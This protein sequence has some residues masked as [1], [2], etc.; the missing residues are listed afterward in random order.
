MKKINLILL[1]FILMVS[2]FY[3]CNKNNNPTPEPANN[4]LTYTADEMALWRQLNNFNQK[5]KTGLKSEEFITPDSAMWYLEALFNV[6]QAKDTT[7]DDVKS[8]ERTYSLN[9]NTNGTVNMSDVVSV[10]NQLIADM[11]YELGQ[12]ESD[13]KFLIIADLEQES[14]KTGSF[15]MTLTAGMGINP[16]VYY[17]PITTTDDWRSG[18][19]HGHCVNPAWDSDAGLELKRRFNNP[20]MA[21]PAPPYQWINPYVTTLLSYEQ[22]PGRIFHEHAS[23]D[24][25]VE[26]TELKSLLTQGHYIIYNTPSETPS[27]VRPSNLQFRLIDLWTNN[28]N[29]T[30]NEYWHKYQIYY[31]TPVSVPPIE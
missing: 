5:I 18:N 13:Y 23:S 11:D 29:P 30:D 16:L 14:L 27:G 19:M 9:V 4:G 21:L 17:Q 1:S 6:Q 25:C 2:A 3:S 24:P 22:F 28:N 12:I 8:Y 7:F 10:Y 26:Y 20:Y 31:G 15:T